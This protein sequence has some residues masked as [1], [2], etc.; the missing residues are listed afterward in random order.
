MKINPILGAGFESFWLGDHIKPSNWAGWAFIP[1]E[2]HNAYLDT[3]LNLGLA[4]LFL[5]LGW[6]IVIYQ[7]RA[8]T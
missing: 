1:N 2:A 6:F 3:Y 8:G 7:R 5:L 4:G